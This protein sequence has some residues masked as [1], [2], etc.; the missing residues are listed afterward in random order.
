MIDGHTVLAGVMGWPVE[1]S[2]SPLLH[3]HWCRIYGVNGAY[4]PLP[5]APEGFEAAL[6]GLAAAGFRGVNV[7]IPHKE[8]AMRACDR[9]TERARRAGAVNTVSFAEGEIVG[10]CTDGIG[11]IEN[12]LA[13]GVTPRG[14]ALVLGAGGAAR[15]VAAALLDEGCE[16]LIANR[17]LTRARALAD[18][19][20][21]GKAVGW[22]DWPELLDGCSLLV[23]ATPL[24][25]GGNNEAARGATWRAT[26]A[27]APDGLTVADIVYTP[28]D[29]PLLVAAR[30]RGLRTVDGLGMLIHQARPGF[31]L[32]F[33]VDPQADEATFNLLAAS[34]R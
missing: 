19:L 3:N 10:D 11:F 1:H 6:R 20:G 33:G 21:A 4:V 18:A 25:M 15:A 31:R 23:N 28:R 34:L 9:L 27:E 16:V 5:T 2:R 7:T 22:P 13:H 17:T 14:R 26:L 8:A 29:T 12:L 30:L 32:W 24:G